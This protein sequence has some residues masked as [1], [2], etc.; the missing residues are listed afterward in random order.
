MLG[1][2]ALFPDHYPVAESSNNM[3]SVICTCGSNFFLEDGMTFTCACRSHVIRE[4]TTVSL[5]RWADGTH[6]R[7]EHETRT[8]QPGSSSVDFQRSP[9]P[10]VFGLPNQENQNVAFGYRN[11]I[12]AGYDPAPDVS[13]KAAFGNVNPEEDYPQAPWAQK[14]RE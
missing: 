14:A 6:G 3:T 9:E 10:V 1:R 13:K 8:V 5:I 2:M 11:V 12:C 7:F 4:G